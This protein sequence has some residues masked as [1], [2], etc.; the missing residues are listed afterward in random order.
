MGNTTRMDFEN[1]VEDFLRD[2]AIIVSGGWTHQTK[3]GG[4]NVRAAAG[5]P[6]F[7]LGAQNTAVSLNA[8]LVE[9]YFSQSASAVEPHLFPFSKP[10]VSVQLDAPGTNAKALP[11]YLIPY[12]GGT[13]HGV[14]LPNQAADGLA[15]AYAVTSAQN[16]C[17]VEVSGALNSPYASHTNVIDANAPHR[18]ATILHRITQLQADYLAAEQ[19]AGLPV[20]AANPAAVNRAQF[21]H[22]NG[23]GGAVAHENYSVESHNIAQN[24]LMGGGVP[25]TRK[26][27]HKQ[28]LGLAG[29]RNFRYRVCPGTA[30]LN[31]AAPGQAQIVAQRVLNSWTFYYQMW[32]P[33]R[34]DVTEKD[35]FGQVTYN[36]RARVVDLNVVLA[37]GQLWP[38]YSQN[39]VAF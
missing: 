11:V 9:A 36:T 31:A 27:H 39:V 20:G 34:F 18:Q 1:N 15:V 22:Y 4:G 37:W 3:S 24:Q 25:V 38:H 5:G 23:P 8:P 29:H 28:G 21:G 26:A 14:K 33:I 2:H 12:A 19:A 6:A 7:V 17:T 35:K 16:G 32:S 10:Q 13:A 30:V